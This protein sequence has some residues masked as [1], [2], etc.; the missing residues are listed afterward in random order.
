MPSKYTKIIRFNQHYKCETKAAIIFEEYNC[1]LKKLD[2]S[3]INLKE[4]LS[5][6]S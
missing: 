4:V 2:I 1:L 5:K 6:S 3:N